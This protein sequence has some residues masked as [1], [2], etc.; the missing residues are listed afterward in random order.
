[1]DFQCWDCRVALP[2]CAKFVQLEVHT[3]M[4]TGCTKYVQHSSS[5]SNPPPSNKER[6]ALISKYHGYSTNACLYVH[7]GENWDRRI[8]QLAKRG[9]G[10]C[11]FVTPRR[12]T[13]FFFC[14]CLS[15]FTTGW[16]RDKNAWLS[17]MPNGDTQD[18]HWLFENLIS[19]IIK[20]VA[21]LWPL[22]PVKSV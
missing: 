8:G 12:C 7:G 21:D 17:N 22:F 9:D 15:I 10:A 20:L 6:R 1:M 18:H 4:N 16:Q 14:L 13:W 19:W 5:C 11:L 3:T 2:F